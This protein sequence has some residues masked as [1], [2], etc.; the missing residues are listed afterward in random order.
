M[1][2]KKFALNSRSACANLQRMNTKKSDPTVTTIAALLGARGG[3][4]RTAAKIKAARRN[5]KKATAASL[6]AR[7]KLQPS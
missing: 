7:L 5:V 6:A 1:V 3:K 2:G 4:A